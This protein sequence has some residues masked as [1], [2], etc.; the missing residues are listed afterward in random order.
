MTILSPSIFWGSRF[1]S[2]R[3]RRG[4]RAINLE[5]QKIEGLSTVHLL[6]FYVHEK[7]ALEDSGR[8]KLRK[9]GYTE[10]KFGGELSS[11]A[12]S[13]QCKTNS[14]TIAQPCNGRAWRCGVQNAVVE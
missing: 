12:R 14:R 3:L 1:F 11:K 2:R 5:P 10:M 6:C 8:T 13:S 4:L 7:K 9:L